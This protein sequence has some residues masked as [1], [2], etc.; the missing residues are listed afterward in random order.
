MSA[1]ALIGRT[2]PD[3]AAICM[4]DSEAI[5]REEMIKLRKLPNTFFEEF[6]DVS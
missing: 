4:E 6:S 3:P 1:L 5:S 2:G